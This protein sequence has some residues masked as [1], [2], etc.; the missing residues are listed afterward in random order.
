MKKV[1]T[2]IAA[3]LLLSSMVMAGDTGTRT[4]EVTV[5]N[6][7]KGINFTPLLGVVHNRNISLFELGQPASDELADLAEGG[8]TGPLQM[9][10]DNSTRVYDTATTSGLLGPG[11]SVSFMIEGKNSHRLFSL[12][13][14]LL[15]TN[16]A[17]VAINSVRL[18]RHGPS[19]VFFARAYDAGSEINDE[20]CANIPG[21][22]CGGT[23]FSAG[24][25]EGYVYVSNGIAGNAD[26]SAEEYNWNN[27]IASVSIHLVQ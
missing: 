17:I 21:P 1:I 9:M 25:A 11:E 12:A 10:L 27:P 4:Y 2:V 15:P 19:T 7:S 14:M 3:G 6:L 26:L 8:D 13:S 20:L 18:P 23:P 24:Q 22:T 5:T 16:D